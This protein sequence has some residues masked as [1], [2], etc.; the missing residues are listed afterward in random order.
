MGREGAIAAGRAAGHGRRRQGRHH[1]QGL[2]RLQ[3]AGHASHRLRRA[4]RGGAGARLPVAH[5]S[6][7]RPA[8]A[9]SAS[10]TAATTRTCWWCASTSWR[11]RRSGA[12]GTSRSTRSSSRWPR[13]TRPI[14]KFMLHIS[15]DEQRERFEKRLDDPAKRWKFRLADLDARAKWGDYMAAYADALSRCSTR[16]APWFVIPGR[17]QVVPRP[18]GGP[19]RGR[20]G[21]PHEPAVS[22]ARGRPDRGCR[23]GL[24]RGPPALP[25]GEA[26]QDRLEDRVEGSAAGDPRA[27]LRDVA[28][29]DVVLALRRVGRALGAAG[30]LLG[31]IRDVDGG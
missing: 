4:D 29:V 23:L 1:P 20:C 30:R 3:P 21:A 18:G 31:G 15:R 22:R 27:L 11:R 7:T 10:S 19:D 2:H 24:S 28:P 8:R 25:L 5:P 17:P 9:G 26:A 12:A 16:H 13:P 6:A 14:L